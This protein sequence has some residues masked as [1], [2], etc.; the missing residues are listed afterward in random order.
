MGKAETQ[1]HHKPLT[2]SLGTHKGGIST[3]GA[4]HWETTPY[5]TPQ[6]LR[7]APE[8][9]APTTSDF[10][11]QLGRPHRRHLALANRG[12]VCWPTSARAQRRSSPLKSAQ[13]FCEKDFTALTVLA[14]GYRG[15]LGNSGDGGRQVRSFALPLFPTLHFYHF[16]FFSS[17][18]RWV[19]SLLPPTPATL[20]QPVGGS[21]P[22]GAPKQQYLPKGNFYT[23]PLSLFVYRLH[24]VPM[25]EM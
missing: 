5:W 23:C 8:R 22:C 3:P 1:S 13:A 16:S 25:Q 14:W 4:S 10:E 7:P 2:P 15:L 6:P 12:L 24:Q 21:P 9:Q 20:L 18:F 17:S 19:P 11:N